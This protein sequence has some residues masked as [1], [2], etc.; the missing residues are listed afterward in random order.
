[1]HYVKCL[2][3]KQIND[4]ELIFIENNEWTGKNAYVHYGNHMPT[5][6]YDTLPSML[7]QLIDSM[8]SCMNLKILAPGNRATTNNFSKK[9]SITGQITFYIYEKAYLVTGALK[10]LFII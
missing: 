6:S 7:I 4:L 1:M 3:I 5:L 8:N 10:L 2:N 9:S